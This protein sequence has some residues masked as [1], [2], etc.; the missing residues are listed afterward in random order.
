MRVTLFHTAD[1]HRATFEALCDAMAPGTELIHVVR[2]DW[3]ARAQGGISAELDTDIAKTIAAADGPALCTCTTIGPVAEAA[4][5]VRVD[6]PM[7]QAAARAGGP[8]VLA[9]C[10]N[11]TLAPSQALLQRALAEA[12]TQAEVR[13]LDLGQ[14]WPLF[15]AGDV[16]AFSSGI[17]EKIR[18]AVTAQGGVGCVVLAQASMAGAAE[19]LADLEVPVLASPE[20]ALRAVLAASATSR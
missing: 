6:W 10:L 15:E 7:M 8:V 20:L 3:L 1:V 11:S 12:E 17:A 16:A 13:L 2:P 4:G 9:Y 5:A 18:Q 19:V 14:C